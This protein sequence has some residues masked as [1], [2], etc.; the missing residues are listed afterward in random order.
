VRNRLAMKKKDETIYR[1]IYE[2]EDKKWKES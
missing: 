2:E 1:V